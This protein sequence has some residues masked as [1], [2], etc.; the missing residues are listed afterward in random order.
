MSTTYQTA[1]AAAAALAEDPTVEARV[2]EEVL[3]GQ[4]VSA[5]VELRLARGVTQQQV[6]DFMRCDASTISRF[7]SGN[8]AKF[9]EVL[10]YLGALKLGMNIL[11]CD[12]ELA[13]NEQ[14]KQCVFELHGNLERLVELAERVQ[15]D[16]NFVRSIHAFF[17]EVQMNFM[18]RFE[19]SYKKLPAVAIPA[20]KRVAAIAV[21][22]TPAI[23]ASPKDTPVNC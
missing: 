3:R 10:G 9:S 19:E 11:F 5:L 21:G 4:L 22:V 16:P 23:L 12:P 20:P 1:A 13:V 2:N 8:D 6:A 14:I 18:T 7:E 17:G 15:D